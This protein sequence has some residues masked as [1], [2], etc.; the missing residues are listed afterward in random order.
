MQ[1]PVQITFF[2]MDASPALEAQI[3]RRVEELEQYCNRITACRVTVA[4]QHRRHQ[5]G[6]L[7]TVDIDLVMPDHE[8]VTG[9]GRDLDHGYEDAHVAVHDAFDALC[10]R[11]EDHMRTVHVAIGGPS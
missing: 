4:A 10:G 11:L 6:N 9:S 1:A 2:Q 3:R 8:I 5:Q 7:F